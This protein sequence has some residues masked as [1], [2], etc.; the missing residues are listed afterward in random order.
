MNSVESVG[1]LQDTQNLY[2]HV[3]EWQI[4]GL[5]GGMQGSSC[6]LS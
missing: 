3:I 2:Y 5:Y 6:E 1:E 4:L